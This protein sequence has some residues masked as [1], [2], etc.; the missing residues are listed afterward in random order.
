MLIQ[1]SRNKHLTYGMTNFRICIKTDWEEVYHKS[2]L[3]LSLSL[4]TFSFFPGAISFKIWIFLLV[5]FLFIMKI[6]EH[7]K[8]IIKYQ[9]SIIQLWQPPNFRCTYMHHLPK[10][11]FYL[12]GGGEYFKANLRHLPNPVYCKKSYSYI[13][14]IPL[15]H[16]LRN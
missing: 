3:R 8:I 10:I 7:T 11:C 9:V 15:F 14:T 5:L 13:T 6:S 4:S 16:L 2:W 1:E 12:G